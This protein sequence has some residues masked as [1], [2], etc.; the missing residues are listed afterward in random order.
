M[1]QRILLDQA[2]LRRLALISANKNDYA[3]VRHYYAATGAR[4]IVV[5]RNGMKLGVQL[6]NQVADAEVATDDGTRGFVFER[7][8]NKLHSKA[9]IFRIVR[10]HYDI[11]LSQFLND[12]PKE[13]Q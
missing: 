9:T 12:A 1:K 6:A 7:N 8:E 3:D 2:G 5:A 10:A 13:E 11:T 4:A